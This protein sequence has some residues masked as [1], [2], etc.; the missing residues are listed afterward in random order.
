MVETFGT[1]LLIRNTQKSNTIIM[2]TG[3]PIIIH[4]RKPN[5]T[6]WLL[7]ASTAIAFGGD[8]IMVPIP[9][10]EA[11]AGIPMSSAFA[12]GEFLSRVLINGITAAI[13]MAVV[14]VFDMIIENIAVTNMIPNSTFLGFEPNFEM[15]ILN[16]VLS[17]PTFCMASAITKPPN[18]NQITLFD[19]V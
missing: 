7:I 3:K 5:C 14:A 10:K 9:P 12:N 1:N 11:A 8:P 16:R 4:S 13:I 18:I 17:S 15:V 19:Q 2:A 6:P